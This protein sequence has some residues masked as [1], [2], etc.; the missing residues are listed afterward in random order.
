MLRFASGDGLPQ[1]KPQPDQGHCVP[2]GGA[3]A[4]PGRT[5]RGL[6]HGMPQRGSKVQLAGQSRADWLLANVRT[7][8]EQGRGFDRRSGRVRVAGWVQRKC[9]SGRKMRREDINP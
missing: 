2:H 3:C 6:L 5:A 7:P 8:V 9:Y 1:P 4:T